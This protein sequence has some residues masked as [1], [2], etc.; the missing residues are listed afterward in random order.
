MIRVYV[1]GPY[2]HGDH[3]VNVRVAIEAAD[4]LF[5]R[6]FIPFVPHLMH[7]WHYIS[8]H[9]YDQ[10]MVLDKEWLPQCTVVLRLPG[11]SPGADAETK[12]AKKLNMP[13]FTSVEDI[14]RAYPWTKPLLKE[15]K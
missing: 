5:V 11:K 9:S 1:A 3:I 14:F 6:G 8:P 10:W 13:V 4:R 2:T 12:L 15:K 7:F